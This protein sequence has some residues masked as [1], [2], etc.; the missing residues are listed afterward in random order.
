M[1]LWENPISKGYISSSRHFYIK[2]RGIE[3]WFQVGLTTYLP[4]NGNAFLVT[5]EVADEIVKRRNEIKSLNAEIS[6]LVSKFE[7]AIYNLRS[8]ARIEKEFQGKW[9]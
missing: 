9:V 2:G 1:L 3:N 7:T 6:N 5:D 4:D 8:Y